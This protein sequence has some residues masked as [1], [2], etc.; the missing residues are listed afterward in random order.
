MSFKKHAAPFAELL[1]RSVQHRKQHRC[2]AYPYKEGSLLQ[3]IAAGVAPN[4]IVEVGTAVGYTAICML[5]AAPGSTIDTIDFDED[6]IA[7]ANGHFQEFGVVGRATAHW[8]DADDVLVTLDDGTY[9]L[10]FFDG[11][12]PTQ[13]IFTSYF[14]RADS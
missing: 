4:K 6:H 2:G 13:S 11:F 7:L 8:G 9:D 5:D 1:D 12:E 14:D 10:G 3:V